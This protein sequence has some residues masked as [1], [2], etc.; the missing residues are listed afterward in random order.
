LFVTLQ[1]DIDAVGVE[2]AVGNVGEET[3]IEMQAAGVYTPSPYSINEVEPKVS[4][5]FR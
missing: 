1:Q 4:L 2:N 3:S 5:V